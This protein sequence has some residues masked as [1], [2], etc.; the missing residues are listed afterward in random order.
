LHPFVHFPYSIGGYDA[1]FIFRRGC[2][3]SLIQLD[4]DPYLS[5][6][7]LVFTPRRTCHVTGILHASS[8]ES[9]LYPSVGECVGFL[10]PLP[11]TQA[12]ISQFRFFLR[13][14]PTQFFFMAHCFYRSRSGVPFPKSFSYTELLDVPL[15]AG[16]LRPV[17]ILPPTFGVPPSPVTRFRNCSP[18]GRI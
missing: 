1:P 14:V 12:P 18:F 8:T 2:P 17:L 5:F 4:E 11:S 13:M 15:V 6:H 9:R 16:L 7:F 3:F 10:V